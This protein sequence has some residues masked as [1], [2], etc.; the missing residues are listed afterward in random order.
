MSRKK[1]ILLSFVILLILGC[2]DEEDKT[3][4]AEEEF[5]VKV[6]SS[7]MQPVAGAT[8]EGGIDWEHFQVQT[9]IS[10]IAVLPG[11]ARGQAAIFYRNNFFPRR[12]D[13]LSPTIYFIT[14]T[15]KQF[16]LIGD[17]AGWAIRFDAG[18][19]ITVDYHGG[20]HV[21]SYNDQAIIEIASAEIPKCIRETQLHGDTLWFSTHDDGIYVYSLENPLN[22]QQ[23]FHLDI[24]GY[25]GS[26]ALKDEI[27]VVGN[28]WDRDL[29]RVYSYNTSGE[30]QEIANF[31]NCLV[32]KMAFI[33][34]Y[35]I[36]VNYYD[37]L[38]AVFNLQN[39][40]E[41]YLVYNGVE[42]DFWSGFLFRNYL[43]LIP[44]WELIGE[45]THYKLVDLSDPTNPLTTGYFSADSRLLEIINDTTA[46]GR[47]YSSSQAISVLS[48]GITW[49]FKTVAIITDDTF[50]Q[51][52]LHEFE[53]CAPPYFIIGKRVWKLEDW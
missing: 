13:S 12:V 26:F 27:I 11:Y 48:G 45:T 21:Y 15:P 2:C 22:P 28:P 31:G 34:D 42:P 3:G 20:Y 8:I 6:L 14:C 16:K 49:G 37:N 43:I 33:S 51:S 39:P 29:L 10:G 41:P 32:V 19:L 7:L 9:D 35:L 47:Y 30:C 23:L 44:L 1:L 50:L 52:F 53:G 5:E 24:P 38:P 46:I 17:I 36:V 25:L 40:A 4:P 18:T